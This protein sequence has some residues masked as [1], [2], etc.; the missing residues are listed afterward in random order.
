MESRFL[1]KHKMKFEKSEFFES[2]FGVLQT[3]F[4]FFK[5]GSGGSIPK[6]LSE[7]KLCKIK[8]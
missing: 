5:G 8:R 6:E 7:K 4:V 2:A 1:E 3:H